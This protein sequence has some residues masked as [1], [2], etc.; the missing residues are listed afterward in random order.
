MSLTILL[1]IPCV[2]TEYIFQSKIEIQHFNVVTYSFFDL[3]ERIWEIEPFI[4][5]LEVTFLFI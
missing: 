2:G 1:I 4:H 5:Y 3:L